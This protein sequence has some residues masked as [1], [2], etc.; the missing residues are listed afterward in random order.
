MIEQHRKLI[1]QEFG[2]SDV[3][4]AA[5]INTGVPA[6]MVVVVVF[7]QELLLQHVVKIQ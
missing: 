6:I 7:V 1:Q 2:L 5:V 4:L 3:V